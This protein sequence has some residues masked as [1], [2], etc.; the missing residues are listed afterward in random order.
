MKADEKAGFSPNKHNCTDKY[1]NET[2]LRVYGH[3]KPVR[4]FAAGLHGDEWRDTTE[5]LMKIEPP[6]KGTLALI[7]L[8]KRGEYTSTLDPAYY[9]VMGLSILEAIEDLNPEIY[10]ELHSYSRENLEKLA[11]R[12]RL[13][14]TGVPAYSVLK[15]G[16][17][18]GSVSPWIRRKYFPKEALC[19]SFEV[20]KGNPGSREF[21]AS[22]LEVLKETESRDEFVE[23]LRKEFPEQARK[24]I[25]DYRRFYGEI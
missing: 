21:V 14:R 8:V 25:E 18:L 15:A 11:G 23:Y 5:I 19:L 20:Q 6:E 10:I 7:P 22:M 24:A 9:Q 1:A 3:G 13:E 16:V 4:L 2:G 12:D 17:L